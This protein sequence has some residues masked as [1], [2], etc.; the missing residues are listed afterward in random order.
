MTARLAR[1]A[2]WLGLTLVAVF[3]MAVFVIAFAFSADVNV[4]GARASVVESPTQPLS[5]DFAVEP[6]WALAAWAVA[7]LLTYV[8]LRRLAWRRSHP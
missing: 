7:S 1:R 6:M 3:Y 5:I 8:L 2:V 4:L